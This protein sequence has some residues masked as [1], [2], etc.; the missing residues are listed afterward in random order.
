MYRLIG[1]ALCLSACGNPSLRSE[2]KAEAVVAGNPA[3]GPLSMCPP[4]GGFLRLDFDNN[5]QLRADGKKKS[6]V[7]HAYAEAASLKILSP[8]DQDFGFLDTVQ[9]VASAG[10]V[11]V[12]LA[13]R[14]RVAEFG[15]TAPYP[16]LTVPL[17]VFTD[18]AGLVAAPQVDIVVKC[19]GRLPTTET[20][21]EARLVLRLEVEP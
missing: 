1:L 15:L 18:L 16:T 2:L 3:G 8:G 19:D 6:Q 12:S 5:P 11:Q 4:F 17:E 14:D 9:L 21:L 7:R 10:D 20:R 13:R